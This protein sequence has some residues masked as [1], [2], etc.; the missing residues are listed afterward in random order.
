M[1]KVFILMFTLVAWGVN[2]QEKT[3]KG[4]LINGVRW[5]TRNLDVGGNFTANPEDYGALYQ[6]GRP[7]DGHESRTSGTTT[8]LATGDT[9]GHD[10]FIL[11]SSSPYDWRSTQND[12]LWNAGTETAPVKAVNDPCP[13]GWRIPTNTEITTLLDPTNVSKA[14]DGT[15][16]GYTF[17]DIANPAN[18]VFF[19]AAGFRRFDN[20][21]VLYA[22]GR[23]YYWRNAPYG[24][25][26]R[27]LYFSEVGAG[28]RYDYR[29]YGQSLR[30]VAE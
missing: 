14:W 20:G 2:A 30:C 17:T 24:I 6:W 22:G 27:Y 12:A 5:A 21:T 4:V 18:S 16:K 3:D 25:F 1:K 10:K 7:A 9:P 15:K 8:T 28:R 13:A 19:P 26:A 29:A 11:A 23:G